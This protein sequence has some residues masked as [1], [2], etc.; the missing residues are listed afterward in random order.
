MG[1]EIG[2]GRSDIGS[3]LSPIC[4]TP[5]TVAALAGHE[6]DAF[7]AAGIQKTGEPCEA[8][9]ADPGLHLGG[10]GAAG[11]EDDESFL[12]S[13]PTSLDPGEAFL[14]WV[15]VDGEMQS[16]GRQLGAV[17]FHGCLQPAT[18]GRVVVLV[19]NFPGSGEPGF[20]RSKV[21]AEEEEIARPHGFRHAP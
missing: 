18:G 11:R 15:G 17:A 8:G 13:D 1:G 4:E 12:R 9:L 5:S 20:R 10:R 7:L 16:A 6:P 3:F 19:E 2:V 14:V 21:G